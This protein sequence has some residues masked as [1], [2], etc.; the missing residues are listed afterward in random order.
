MEG[1]SLLPLLR[2]EAFERGAPIFWEH[3]GNRA[4]RDGRWKL[5]SAYPGRWEL[6]DMIGD[7]TEL[8][9]L[10]KANAPVA[11]RLAAAHDEWAARAG[12][13]PWERLR[14]QG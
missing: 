5:V 9:D 3:E 13:I 7:R 14:G 4:V 2:G 10:S 8:H 11:A 6:Y 1:R 12:V